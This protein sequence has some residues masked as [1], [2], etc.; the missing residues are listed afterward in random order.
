[1][2]YIEDY[3]QYYCYTCGKYDSEFDEEGG[4]GGEEMPEGEGP[5]EEPGGEE[6]SGEGPAGEEP[7]GEEP[8]GEGGTE[9]EE[10]PP[11]Q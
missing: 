9:F 11:G 1:M 7:S 2:E 4:E 6:P 3:D 10:T 5:S 8:P